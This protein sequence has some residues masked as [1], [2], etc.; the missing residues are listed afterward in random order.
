VTITDGTSNTILLVEG[1]AHPR[2][3]IG[4]VDMTDNPNRPGTMGT[5]GNPTPTC[6][7]PYPPGPSGISV[8]MFLSHGGGW[9]DTTSGSFHLYGSMFDSLVCFVSVPRVP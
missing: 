9:A 7:D 5:P 2:Y 8:G 6:P 1:S 3:M 4:R